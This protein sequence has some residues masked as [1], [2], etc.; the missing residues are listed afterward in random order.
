MKPLHHTTIY[1][2]I[3]PFVKA[4]FEKLSDPALMEWCSRCD[5]EPEQVV[6]QHDLE[7]VLKTQFA[8]PIVVEI[9][10]HIAVITFNSGPG[11]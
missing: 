2:E 1:P 8:S 7:S 10:V 9:A 3:A 4:E 5:P 11:A 6:Q